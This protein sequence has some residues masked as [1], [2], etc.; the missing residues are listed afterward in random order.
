MSFF[1]PLFSLLRDDDV[2]FRMQRPLGLVSGST[3]GSSSRPQPHRGPPPRTEVA[4][5]TPRRPINVDRLNP[6]GAPSK[7]RHVNLRPPPSG[8]RKLNFDDL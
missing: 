3:A 5:T 7:A 1:A 6:P 2:Q 4:P 8:G